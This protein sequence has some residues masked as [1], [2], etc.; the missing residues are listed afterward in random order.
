MAFLVMSLVALGFL[1][2]LP[3]LLLKVVFALIWLPFRLLGLVL[4]I[5]FGVLFGVIGV[6]FSGAG[7]VLAVILALGLALVIPLLPVFLI[8]FGLWLLL[9][10]TTPKPPLR[11][12]A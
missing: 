11:L 7:I 2:L 8:G 4:R 10:S 6:V 9:R 3:L 1:V 5:V 12:S